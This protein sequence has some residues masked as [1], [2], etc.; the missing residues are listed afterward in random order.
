MSPGLTFEIRQ[1]ILLENDM[2][3]ED[4]NYI[5]PHAANLTSNYYL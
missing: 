3:E 2:N 5:Y 4:M 1:K